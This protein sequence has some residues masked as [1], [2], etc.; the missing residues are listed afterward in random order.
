MQQ[1]LEIENNFLFCFENPHRYLHK[2]RICGA[3]CCVSKHHFLLANLHTTILVLFSVREKLVIIFWFNF[4]NCSIRSYQGVCYSIHTC[5]ISII[6]KFLERYHFNHRFTF[7]MQ[8]YTYSPYF[9]Q[10]I[11]TFKKGLF[12]TSPEISTKKGQEGLGEAF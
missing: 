3:Q 4:F 2:S 10:A 8:N 6:L 1:W 9:F 12:S 5:N 11:S 7:T